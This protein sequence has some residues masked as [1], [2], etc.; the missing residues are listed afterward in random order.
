MGR[1]EQEIL[2]VETLFLRVCR[3]GRQLK[4]AMNKVCFLA[5]LIIAMFILM[6]FIHQ[7]N[8]KTA[9]NVRFEDRL[10]FFVPTFSILKKEEL[11]KGVN[12]H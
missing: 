4:K 6:P 1:H 3:Q 7:P 9:S 11:Y 10:K 5:C 8:R 12:H 2:F